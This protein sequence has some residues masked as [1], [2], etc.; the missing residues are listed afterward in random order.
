MKTF[1]LMVLA[2]V[3]ALGACGGQGGGNGSDKSYDACQLVTADEARALVGD[4]V[5]NTGG[6]G[7]ICGWI[8]EG[9]KISYLNVSIGEGAMPEGGQNVEVLRFDD[10]GDGAI[11]MVRE[12]D[13]IEFYVQKGDYVLRL[14]M[15]FLDVPP[16]GATF[17]EVKRVAKAAAGRM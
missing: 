9:E 2:T 17:E 5:T 7:S 1:N 10:I 4:P 6:G 13:V 16:D 11:A 8:P 3:L 14:N 15:P 12:G